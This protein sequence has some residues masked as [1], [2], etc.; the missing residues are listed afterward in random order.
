MEV[1]HARNSYRKLLIGFA[2]NNKIYQ[3]GQQ[4]AVVLHELSNEVIYQGFFNLREF[5]THFMQQLKL[6]LF[7]LLKF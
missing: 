7:F 6:Y 1:Y 4:L 3:M 5:F 2:E